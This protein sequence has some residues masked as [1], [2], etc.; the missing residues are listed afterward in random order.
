MI[1]IPGIVSLSPLL[2]GSGLVI[3]DGAST[4]IH[5]NVNIF[6]YQAVPRDTTNDLAIAPDSLELIFSRWCASGGDLSATTRLPLPL[7]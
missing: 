3:S 4:C 1:G 5:K 7:P 6:L 2:L